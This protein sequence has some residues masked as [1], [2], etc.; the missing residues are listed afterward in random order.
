MADLKISDAA[1][2]GTLLATDRAP[3]AR[4]G[5]TTAYAATM[6]ELATF[7]N[8]AYVPNYYTGTPSM[9]G[10]GSAGTAAF[11]SRG[12]HVHPSDTS[13]APLASP[14]FTGIP[15]APT[16]TTG[17]NTTQLATTAFVQ[18][19]MVASGA[20][21]STWNTRAG[22]VVLQEAD[23]T[24]VG[25]LHDVGRNLLHNPLFNVA[26]RGA[27]PWTAPNSYTADRWKLDPGNA[28][29]TVSVSL[30]AF[31]DAGRAA[32]GDEAAT[33]YL[34]N[35]FTGNAAAGAYNGIMQ[36]IEGVR[37]LAGK[38]VVVSFWAVAAS[39]TPKLGITWGQSFGT[40]G[41]PSATVWAT[42]GNSVTLSTTWTRYTTTFNLPS[43][44]G[45][46]VGT[47]GN[48]ATVLEFVYSSGATNNA[49]AG[50]I[51]VQ[52]G[53]ISIWGVQLEIGSVATLLEKPDPQQDLAKAQRF[54]WSALIYVAPASDGSGTQLIYPTTMRAAPTITGG[55]AGFAS[56][57]ASA[58]GSNMAQTAGGAQTLTFSADI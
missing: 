33:T 9:D 29:D 37:R 47:N 57:A 1:D 44:S 48:D 6:A 22:A 11:V 8:G 49:F 18:S 56:G 39:G 3:I 41:S 16:A 38:T 54:Y 13:R 28:G 27:G 55:G 50:N 40:G 2:A 4:S 52:S 32:I 51:G 19:Q 58:V 36:A 17:T 5:S 42:T 15:A 26:Q 31:V 30:V 14:T 35:V 43:A 25:A 12:D 34:Q 20:G 7:A 24:A 45:K 10:T 23:I 21:V 46:T 53:T